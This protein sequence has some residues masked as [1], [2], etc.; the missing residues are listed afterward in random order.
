MK[1][2]GIHQS[3]LRAPSS[4]HWHNVHNKGSEAHREDALALAVPYIKSQNIYSGDGK[5][6]KQILIVA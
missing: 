3:S 5:F 2:T 1:T 6:T 4:P